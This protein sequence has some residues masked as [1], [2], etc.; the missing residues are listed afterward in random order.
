MTPNPGAAILRRLARKPV[1]QEK[2]MFGLTQ[3]GVV[4][5]I[6][7][8]IAVAAGIA[9]FARHGAI[10]LRTRSGSVYVVM[11]VLT[12]LTGFPIF[13]H[14]GFGPPHATGVLALVLLAFAAGLEK[15]AFLGPVSHVIETV[16]Y[17]ATF[18]LHM[19]PAVNETLTRIPAG[20]PLAS[21][22][23]D[24]LVLGLV[25]VAFV[26][27]VIG[28]TVQVARLRALRVAARPAK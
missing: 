3:L 23:Q 15:Q 5:T 13:Q 27:F 16:T 9:A 6:I 24:P 8:L 21:G 22:P 19:I 20:A 28:A 10:S 12:C 26:G 7:S 1:A 17:T 25:G 11:T 4:H 18:F 14:G 2:P